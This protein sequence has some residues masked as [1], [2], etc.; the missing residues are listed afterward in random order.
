MATAPLYQKYPGQLAAQPAYVA[1]VN[2]E[3]S[4]EA[5]PE[6]GNAVPMNVHHG[7]ALRWSVDNAL[8]GDQVTA[9]L[10]ELEPLAKRVTAGLTVDWNGH[11]HVGTLDA[12]AQAASDEIEKLCAFAEGAAEIWQVADWLPNETVDDMVKLGATAAEI[13]AAYELLAKQEGIILVDD[14][15][16]FVTST[17]L[18]WSKED[19]IGLDLAIEFDGVDDD[20]LKFREAADSAASFGIGKTGRTY[21]DHGGPRA[22]HTTTLAGYTHPAAVADGT[23]DE[24]AYALWAI[25]VMR[26]LRAAD[27]R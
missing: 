7:I 20:V 6:I 23:A 12:D 26:R 4:A 27:D 11:N 17:L 2:G 13:A 1:L 18:T 9:L 24:L 15:E 10:A 16:A 21:E 5:S 14:V 19:W 8:T 3:L 22:M 25:N